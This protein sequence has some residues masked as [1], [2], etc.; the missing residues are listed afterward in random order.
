MSNAAQATLQKQLRDLL[1]SPIPGFIVGLHKDNIFEWDVG[2][3]GPPGTMYAGGYFKCTIKFSDQY[4]FQPP[5]FTFNTSLLHPNIY[6]DG[7]LCISILHPP[8][9][10]PLSGESAAERWNP[11][12]SVESILLSVLSLLSDP[13]T[14]SPANV[15]AGVM[16][17]QDPVKYAAI[18]KEQVE[19]SKKDIPADVVMPC[20][21][22]DL[23]TVKPPAPKA[24]VEDDTFWYDDE[25]EDFAVSSDGD[26][27]FGPSGDTLSSSS[28]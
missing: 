2:I 23:F 16:Y 17:R 26:G 24:D 10:D 22:E 18:V 4:P 19:L 21:A 8:G 1:K 28:E 11:T 7:K 5:T 6:P 27:D 15:D 13:N 3:I 20:S 12:Q 9:D 14:S 25:D